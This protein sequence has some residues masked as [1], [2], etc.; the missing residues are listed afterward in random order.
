MSKTDKQTAQQDR[1]QTA[2]KATPAEGCVVRKPD[3]SVLPIEGDTINYTADASY[4]L[5][6]EMDGDVILSPVEGDSE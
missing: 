2:V 6:R 1:S 3:G 4:W 5:R